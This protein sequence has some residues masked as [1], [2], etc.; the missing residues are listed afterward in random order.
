MPYKKV[1]SQYV[2]REE[3]FRDVPDNQSYQISNKGRIWS[4]VRARYLKRSETT[5]NT[6]RDATTPTVRVALSYEGRVRQIDLH[7]LR[8]QVWP[9]LYKESQLQ[10]AITQYKAL[11]D[12]VSELSD[13]DL[14]S[15]IKETQ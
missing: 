11:K 10:V 7:K 9:E 1:L 8:E 2:Y 5:P 6:P 3:E 4:K 14:V 13:E 12:M 15:Y